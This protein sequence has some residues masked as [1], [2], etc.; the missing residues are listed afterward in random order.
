MTKEEFF[1]KYPDVAFV[2]STKKITNNEDC[3]IENYVLDDDMQD[4]NGKKI[5]PIDVTAYPGIC[6]TMTATQLGVWAYSK[7]VQQKWDFTPEN[8]YCCLANLEMDY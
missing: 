8:V 1:E 6:K 7:C 2:K 4:L 3:K 5:I